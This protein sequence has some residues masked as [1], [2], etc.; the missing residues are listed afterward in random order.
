MIFFAVC[1]NKK[2]K[3]G[4]TKE[5]AQ[6]DALTLVRGDDTHNL[7]TGHP[8]PFEWREWLLS[9]YI[10]TIYIDSVYYSNICGNHIDVLVKIKAE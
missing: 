8:T 2:N 5:V 1:Y 7:E 9:Y 4:N 6:V 3:R 10:T